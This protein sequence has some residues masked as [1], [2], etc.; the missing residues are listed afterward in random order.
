MVGRC[1][2]PRRVSLLVALLGTTQRI[3][4]RDLLIDRSR[5]H[6]DDVFNR[7]FDA[8]IG[9]PRRKIE[10]EPARPRQNKSERG[11][12]YVFAVLVQTIY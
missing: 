2:P 7:S 1:R 12:G 4:T 3:L 6:S 8:Q 5:L 11:A 9:R 10:S